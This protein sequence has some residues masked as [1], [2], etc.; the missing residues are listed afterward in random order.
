ME[1]SQLNGNPIVGK[2]RGVSSA[3]TPLTPDQQGNV[4]IPKAT[5]STFGV[6]EFGS[7][8]GIDG[9]NGIPVINKSTNVEIEAKSNNYKP[10]V[11]ANLDKAI[12]EGLGN[13]NLGTNNVN[14]WSDTYKSHAREVI[15]AVGENDVPV[16][17]ISAGGTALTPDANGNVNIPVDQTYNATST[18]PQSG[19]A[20]AQ[21]VG[22]KQD[23]LVSGTNVKTINGES[24]LGSGDLVIAGGITYEEVV[25]G[26]TVTF[27]TVTVEGKNASAGGFVVT[28]DG[29]DP[30]SIYDYDLQL[31]AED[32]GNG[33]WSGDGGILTTPFVKSGITVLKF[34]S[35]GNP[36]TISLN[37]VKVVDCEEVGDDTI[38][39]VNVTEDCTLTGTAER[40]D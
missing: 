21:A 24:I 13:Y 15:G 19:L 9:S 20:V 3:G 7:G 28:L 27:S 2:L 8:Y 16:K 25:Q 39:T 37:G 1:I 22:T 6:V 10:L 31:S 38:Y 35:V 33:E 26:H 40:T 5:G 23:V 18:K 12:K 30:D 34:L 29:R 11:P 32:Y 4:N 36:F 17:S 14:A